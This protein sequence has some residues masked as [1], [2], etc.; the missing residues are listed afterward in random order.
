MLTEARIEGA[1]L[2]AV[3]SAYMPLE[4][5]RCFRIPDGIPK[6]GEQCDSLIATAMEGT[7]GLS[8]Q[9]GFAQG[10]LRPA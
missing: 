1:V 7:H 10:L 9:P 6:S 3:G 8:L 5:V 2:P 4:R